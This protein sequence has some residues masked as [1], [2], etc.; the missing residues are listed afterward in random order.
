MKNLKDIL[1]IRKFDFT[2]IQLLLSIIA[3][4]FA[5]MIGHA[6]PHIATSEPHK[7]ILRNLGGELDVICPI[8]Y[9]SD[10]CKAGVGSQ[11]CTFGH[12]GFLDN[13]NL[14]FLKDDVRP[15][16]SSVGRSKAKSQNDS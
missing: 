2:A 16:C 7:P 5:G 10:G 14:P 8:P 11:N 4:S 1:E 3:I 12:I 13:L 6:S 9:A 15:L